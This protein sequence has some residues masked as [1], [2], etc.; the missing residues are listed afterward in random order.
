MW[1]ARTEEKNAQL[2]WLTYETVVET[3]DSV[4]RLTRLFQLNEWRTAH[5][6]C[7]ERKRSGTNV[8][9]RKKPNVRR[10]VINRECMQSEQYFDS[11]FSNSGI[12]TTYNTNKYYRCAQIKSFVFFGY[13]PIEKNFQF[14]NLFQKKVFQKSFPNTTISS[15][16]ERAKKWIF[17]MVQL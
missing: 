13:F 3:I 10:I 2:R 12:H 9:T 15:F 17:K 1:W 7:V 14:F 5:L 4:R 8:T 11:W 6:D 16:K